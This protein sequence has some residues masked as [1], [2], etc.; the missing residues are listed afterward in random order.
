MRKN[1]QNSFSQSP[2]GPPEN[3]KRYGRALWAKV[4]DQYAIAD[5]GGTEMLGQACAAADVA[6][7]CAAK[8]K[9]EGLTVVSGSGTPHDHPLLRHELA[10]RAFVVKTLRALGLNVEPLR[11]PGRPPAHVPLPAGLMLEGEDDDGWFEK[12]S[13]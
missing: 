1:L 11:R 13:N 3:L 10:A 2:P 8:I 12:N 4:Q 5:V 6:E 9:S 7:D